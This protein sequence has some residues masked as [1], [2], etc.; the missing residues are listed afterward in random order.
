[1]D[2]LAKAGT[3]IKEKP[4]VNYA[5]SK[6]QS[7]TGSFAKKSQDGQTNKTRNLTNLA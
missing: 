1:M 2:D 6:H 7:E 3:E 4:Q 5:T